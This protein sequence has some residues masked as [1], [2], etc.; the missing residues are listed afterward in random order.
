MNFSKENVKMALEQETCPTHHEQ[1]TVT[2][3]DDGYEI[4]ACCDE[5]R[6]QLISK[7]E[8]ELVKEAKSAITNSFKNLF[9]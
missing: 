5:F 7:A 1:P 4:K 9:N 2:I 8:E 6:T 3:T